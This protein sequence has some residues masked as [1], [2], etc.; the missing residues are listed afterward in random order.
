MNIGN[1]LKCYFYVP[2]TSSNTTI[3]DTYGKEKDPSIP[4]TPETIFHQ[5]K[6]NTTSLFG[7]E[8]TFKMKIQ[9]GR[10]I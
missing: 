3:S 9:Y 2:C 8:L 7:V 1:S 6:R 5:H 10:Q 4:R